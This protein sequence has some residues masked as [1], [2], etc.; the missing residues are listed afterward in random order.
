MRKTKIFSKVVLLL[1]GISMALVGAALLASTSYAGT[2]LCSGWAECADNGYTHH[3]YKDVIGTS[4][5]GA[6]SGNNCTN[7]VSYVLSAVNGFPNQ[8]S[9]GNGED[10]NDNAADHSATVDQVPAVGSVAQWENSSSHRGGHVAYVEAVSRTYKADGTVAAIWITI[11]QDSYPSGPFN[12]KKMSKSDSDWPDNFIHF[13]DMNDSPATYTEADGD[14]WL[15]AVN[16]FG[17]LY[18]QKF[19]A[20]TNNWGSS[21][22]H[23]GGWSSKSSPAITADIYGNIWVA[24]VKLDGTLYAKYFSSGWS[25]VKKVDDGV[26]IDAGVR[27]VQRTNGNVTPLYVRDDGNIRHANGNTASTAFSP[28]GNHF[29]GHW[30]TT[31]MP[32]LTVDEG[33]TMWASAVKDSGILYTWRILSSGNE[34]HPYN[35]NAGEYSVWGGIDLVARPGGNVTSVAIASD[36]DL[37]HRTF[38]L[39]GSSAASH[40]PNWMKN[41][42]PS[43]TLDSSDQLWIAGIK[44]NRYAY[45]YYYDGSWNSTTVGPDY[46]KASGVD[47]QLRSNG[48]LILAGVNEDR[49]ITHTSWNWG[50]LDWDNPTTH[51]FE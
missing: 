11:S 28:S 5:W 50:T 40:D 37:M 34:L 13:Y 49:K 2:S 18:T 41:A 48:A 32:G 35:S 33:G 16:R 19:D 46:L 43:V 20:S 47:I 10:W 14:I 21:Q 17:E 25:P 3:G 22:Y 42:S 23:S 1:F 26:S 44:L 9:L 51:P 7:Y 29:T 36:G 8:S 12:W 27:L 31:S 24:A 6:A 30:S 4:H 39:T 45:A 15:A 38:S